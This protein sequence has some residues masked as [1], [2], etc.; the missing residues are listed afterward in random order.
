MGTS[1]QYSDR[2]EWPVL[3]FTE[4]PAAQT[5]VV[6]A[7]HRAAE[8]TRARLR[9]NDLLFEPPAWF[10][11]RNEY[12]PGM[13]GDEATYYV[14]PVEMAPNQNTPKDEPQESTLW[15]VLKAKDA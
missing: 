13:Q 11:D 10:V 2:T 3:A 7:T 6:L 9:R 15:D 4:E 14:M 12:D 1:G 8:I 5:L